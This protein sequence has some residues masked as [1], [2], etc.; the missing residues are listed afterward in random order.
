MLTLLLFQSSGLFAR[1]LLSSL[2]TLSTSR[3]YSPCA[4]G[5]TLSFVPWKMLNSLMDVSK[6]THVC[7]YHEDDVG[8]TGWTTAT[9]FCLPTF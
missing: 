7:D 3:E 2:G 1:W 8:L 9:Q 5:P 6:G 4:N